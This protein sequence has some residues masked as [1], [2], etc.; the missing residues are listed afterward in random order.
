M[1][2]RL[3]QIG[4]CLFLAGV[5]FLIIRNNT[6]PWPVKR[7]SDIFFLLSVI[8]VVFYLTYYKEWRSYFRIVLRSLW[9]IGF[10]FFGIAL[11]SA[12]SFFISHRSLETEGLLT[13]FRFTE[14]A[15]LLLMVVFFQIH[16]T[17]WYRKIAWAQLSTLIYIMVFIIPNTLYYTQQRFQLFENW[18]SNVGYYVVVSLA[19]LFVFLLTSSRSRYLSLGLIMGSVG[20]TAILL[21]TASRASWLSFMVISICILGV[22]TYHS[23]RKLFTIGRGLGIIVLVFITAFLILPQ[24]VKNEVIGRVF[25]DLRTFTEQSGVSFFEIRS[26]DLLRIAENKDL[27]PNLYDESRP[28]LWW[29]YSKLIAA[30]PLGLGI[31]APVIQYK[32]TPRGTHNTP[33]EVLLIGG[34]IGLIGYGYVWWLVFQNL[35]IHPVK[36]WS[37]WRLYVFAALVGLLVVSQFDGMSMFRLIWIFLGV[38]ISF[39]VDDVQEES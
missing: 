32:G 15:V 1:G 28:Q 7:A 13:L 29:A 27:T 23:S 39:P 38:G 19:L 9:G 25:P 4:Q 11:G 16:D 24:Q 2:K 8:C 12:L 34:A 35:F 3:I 36:S 17:R 5:S 20:L 18:P 21:W 33:L 22:T 30:Q 31:N 6:Y 26:H 10:L 14:C 37:S